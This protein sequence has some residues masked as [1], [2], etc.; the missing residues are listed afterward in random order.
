MKETGKMI[1]LMGK[2]CTVILM[3]PNT[4]VLGS[5][6]VKMGTALRHGR[7]E[8]SIQA[9]IWKVRNMGRVNSNGLT[10]Q[11]TLVSSP[12]TTSKVLGYTCGQMVA[13]SKVTGRTTKWMAKVF[14]IG[15]TVE[16]MKENISMIR[17]TGMVCSHGLMVVNMKVTGLKANSMARVL[18]YLI[19]EIVVQA[20]G[21]TANEKSGCNND[22]NDRGFGVLG[23][24]GFGVLGY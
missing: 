9:A 24:W 18:T 10:V 15:Q 6:I 8:H 2:E 17:N 12:T 20:C 23:F 22:S 16:F 19:E 4:P 1:K 11:H 13:S 21:I 5:R 14:S 3:E 7:T